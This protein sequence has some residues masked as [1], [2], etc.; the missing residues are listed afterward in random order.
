VGATAGLIETRFDSRVIQ[1]FRRLKTELPESLARLDGEL[2]R[3]VTGY[4]DACRIPHRRVAEA[5]WWV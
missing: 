1:V 3:L 2:E 5:V 4:L